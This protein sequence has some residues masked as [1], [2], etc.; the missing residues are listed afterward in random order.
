MTFA[1]R[2][3]TFTTVTGLAIVMGKKFTVN[4]EADK[5]VLE[6]VMDP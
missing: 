4:Y 5:V 1:S 6:V 2:V 3:G